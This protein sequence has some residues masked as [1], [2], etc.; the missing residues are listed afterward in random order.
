MARELF[1]SSND[2][3]CGAGKSSGCGQLLALAELSSELD[4][5]N[6]C[7]LLLRLRGTK[8]AGKECRILGLTCFDE[9]TTDYLSTIPARLRLIWG[10]FWRSL[11][12]SQKNLSILGRV[13]GQ[14]SMILNDYPVRCG[15]QEVKLMACLGETDNR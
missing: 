1:F 4:H 9:T 6:D 13:S 10:G 15:T 7:K 14:V 11:L 5:D 8:F 3:C 12:A 2:G